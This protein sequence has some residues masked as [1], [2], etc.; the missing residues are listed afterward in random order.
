MSQTAMVLIGAVLF[1]ALM[2]FLGRRAAAR[3]SSD[4]EDFFLANRGLKRFVLLAAIFGTN[5]S[6]FVMLGVAGSSYHGGVTVGLMLMGALVFTMPLSFYFGYRCWIVAKRFGYIT[7]V[8]FYRE[9]FGSDGLGI[10]LFLCFVAWTIP[11]VLTGVVGGGRA[12]QSFTGGSV[13]YWVGGLAVAVVVGY[14]TWA[15]GMKGTAWTNA[16]QTAL[17]MAFLALAVVLVPWVLGGTGKLGAQLTGQPQLLARSW[18][19]PGGFGGSL[20]QFL[21]F[22]FIAFGLPYVWIRMISAR[23]GRDLRFSGMA[24]PVA[25]ILTWVPAILLGVWGASLIPGLVGP[26]ADSI[27][28][29]ITGQLLP[30]W[31]SAFG[32]IALLSIVMSS[33]DAQILTLS[34]MLSRDVVAR[35]L[36]TSNDKT[37][38]RSAR[39]F[40]LALLAITYGVSLMDLPAVFDL[41]EFAVTGF[42]ALYP[43]L[44]GGIFW[45]R[46][47]K[48]GA[49]ASVI[50]AQVVVVAGYL[51]AYPALGGLQPVFWGLLAGTV[52]FVG[53]SLATPRQDAAA[54]RFHDV[55]DAMHRRLSV[56]SSPAAGLQPGAETKSSEAEAMKA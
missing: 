39:V 9:R 51:G 21:A 1:V 49:I 45:R 32:L 53:V 31:L 15:G 16:A 46:A 6:A 29:M 28:F 7:P 52:V 13:P 8:E 50:T 27:I 19:G 18:D 34:N 11:L 24:Y 38:V 30:S 10:L 2:V 12:L 54:A 37:Q 36:R 42:A 23:S 40:V 20:S 22:S 56:S 41:A 55:W 43:V 5:M 44:I 48:W 4:S 14:Y 26:E 33:M 47:N 25:I 35:Y 3:T 17:F